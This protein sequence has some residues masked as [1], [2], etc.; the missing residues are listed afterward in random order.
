[1]NTSIVKAKPIGLALNIYKWVEY[2]Q[3]YYH[4]TNTGKGYKLEQQN[5][6][7]PN[8]INLLVIHPWS[9][10]KLEISYWLNFAESAFGNKRP[11]NL[12]G[13][14]DIAFTKAEF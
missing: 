6:E 14:D 5:T 11:I 1:M 8:L 4:N 3:F 9:V 13:P 10:N 7:Q 2:G 12:I